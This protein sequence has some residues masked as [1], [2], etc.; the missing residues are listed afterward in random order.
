[1]KHI[2]F[3]FTLLAAPMLWAADAVSNG[4]ANDSV[5][6]NR[7]SIDVQLRT[8]AEYNGGAQT[9][10]GPTD[11]R[12]FF[13]NNRAR[14]GL[15]YQY[16]WL[17]LKLSAQHTGVWG[18]D[19]I[20]DKFGRVSMNEAWARMCW[21]KE[22]EWF[23]QVGRQQFSYD[24]ERI[25]GGLD[26][27]VAGNWHD[28]VRLGYEGTEHRAHIMAA[29]NQNG[30]NIRG[31]FYQHNTGM[32]YRLLV[33]AWYHY[34]PTKVPVAFS[35]LFLNTGFEVGAAGAAKMAHMQTLGAHF[36]AN[37]AN[38]NLSASYYYQMGYNNADRRTSAMMAAVRANYAV[39]KELSLGVGY[40]YMSGAGTDPA[41]NNAFNPLYGT[42][43][44]FYG[45]MDY[46]YASPWV[47]NCGLHDALFTI[48]GKPH[49]KVSLGMTYHYFAGAS[50]PAGMAPTL[51]HELDFSMTAKLME[52][53]TLHAG[54]SFMVGTATMDYAKGGDHTR[55]NDWAF[56]SLNV[57]P[58]I[59][60]KK[61]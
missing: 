6:N 11:K 53:I 40:D 28:A 51:G 34:Q 44:K 59:F 45:A 1:M 3:L 17:E 15:G 13:I 39:L 14:I 58:R 48:N 12:A 22:Q 9:P 56:V 38:W 18:Q 54:Y 60:N 31:G 4:S 43:H 26:W 50:L 52:F 46:F 36:T 30:E 21:G 61:W 37:P 35:A 2:V 47:N 7:F 24:D 27:N 57:N 20:K 42:H 29:Y 41:V 8:R 32:P 55:W 19:D 10:L 25:L 16:K 23:A 5:A 49:K 33:G